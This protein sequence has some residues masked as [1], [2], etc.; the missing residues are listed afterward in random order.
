MDGGLHV[1]ELTKLPIDEHLSEIVRGVERHQTVIVEAAPG[2]GKTT[3]IPSRLLDAP[4]L[5]G[6]ILVSE[7]RRIAA[8][9]AATRVSEERQSR[10][11]EEVGYRVRFDERAG[12]A[13]R[14]TFLT[15]GLL[16]SRLL[17]DVTL[18]SVGLV[19]LDEVHERSADLDLALA[20]L[21][22]TLKRRQDFRLVCMSATL[23]SDALSQYLGGAL[24]FRS[25][26]T[27]F[28]VNVEH[29]KAADDRP[30]EI[31]VR[32][33][34]RTA[35]SLTADG[36]TLVFLPGEREIRRCEEALREKISEPVLSLHGNMSL[37]EQA[38]VMRH[39]P[40]VRRIILSTNL[41]ESSVT[42]P[43]VTV[44][45]DSGLA[46][47][48]VYDPW[49]GVSRLE[50]EFISRARMLQRTGR[51]GRVRAG[52]CL[53]LYSRGHFDAQR[54]YDPPE[55]LRTNLSHLL[56]RLLMAG[57]EPH[58]LKFLTAPD[59]AAWTSALLELRALGAA[60]PENMALTDVG[61]A[62]APLSLPPRLARVVIE[63]ERLGLGADSAL[64]ACLLEQRDVLLTARHAQAERHVL[65]G[66]S[67]ITDRIERLRKWEEDRK[68]RAS[69][70][71]LDL[72]F[73]LAERILTAAR[74]NEKAARRLCRDLPPLHSSRD[75]LSRALLVGFPDRVAE[76]RGT[77]TS[78]VLTS[79]TQVELSRAS[80]VSSGTFL[81]AVSVD[82]PS[83]RARHPL[84]RLACRLEP[85]WL[86]E[87]F[88]NEI[89]ATETLVYNSDKGR[90]DCVSRLSYGKVVLDETRLAAKA[91]ETAAN[92]FAAALLLRGPGVYDPEGHLPSF[93]RRL[94]LLLEYE[95]EKISDQE[96]EALRLTEGE[97]QT[98]VLSEISALALKGAA[99]SCPTLDEIRATDLSQELLHLLPEQ[100]ARKLHQS[101]PREISLPSG[102]RLLVHYD[103]DRIPWIESRLQNFFSLSQTP[104]IC[105]GR[106][107]LQVHLLAPN[108]RALQVTT[109]L[110]GFWERH[111]PELRKQLMR[112][113]PK[114]LWP[115]DGRTARPPAPGKIR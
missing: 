7:P 71:H 97:P 67:D 111:Y 14:L 17:T 44:V 79:G 16:L 99:L 83:G 81:L 61:R 88:S 31:Q 46:R 96:R 105:S 86:V 74:Q 20:L 62:M 89:Q 84:V 28:P 13:T 15:E 34:V 29:Q 65:S 102:M 26:G 69:A 58:Q 52:H 22:E 64:A 110:G 106:L 72:D 6:E 36:D 91:G 12:P 77:G 90:V 33:A 53:R 45:I 104:T 57:H 19:I 112:R 109:D 35:L 25:E 82:A 113:Y 94:A 18:P 115:Q 39:T 100:L 21:T 11:G 9:M 32:S 43:G 92:V 49:S 107:P 63:G 47:S 98:L 101:V 59:P 54:E 66:D 37:P 3:R 55:L 80:C 76:R 56:L 75:L 30:L 68:S 93:C 42:L 27:A 8:K 114:H 1:R 10:L 60:L 2:A 4:F 108:K 103:E 78:L 48:S 51:A 70:R 23:D 87:C 24:C 5:R 85:D 41:A 73:P 50:T 38:E 95:P 40:E